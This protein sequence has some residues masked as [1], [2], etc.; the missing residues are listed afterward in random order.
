MLKTQTLKKL[1]EVG[2][3]ACFKGMINEGETIMEAVHAASPDRTPV[4]IGLAVARI[5][6]MRYDEAIKLLRDDILESE[7]QNMTA[8][9]FLGL[10][11]QESGKK[12]EGIRILTEVQQTGGEHEQ[13]IAK[14]YLSA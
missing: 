14:A 4:K 13:T 3:M 5:S 8:K 12:S 2:Y 10:A 7:P 6:A 1:S 11:L 9:C